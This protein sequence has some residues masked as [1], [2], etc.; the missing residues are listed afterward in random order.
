MGLL[1]FNYGLVKVQLVGDVIFFL[2]EA[3]LLF[4]LSYHPQKWGEL[5]HLVDL[6]KNLGKNS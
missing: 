6:G 1:W 3:C 5:T 4:S 2:G